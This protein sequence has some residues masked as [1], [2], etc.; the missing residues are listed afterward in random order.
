VVVD[1][2][3]DE[4]RSGTYYYIASVSEDDR[5]K[6]KATGDVVGFR[7]LGKNAK[8]EHVLQQVAN[9][10]TPL[11]K[12][13]CSEPC[14]II[15]SGNDL[16]GF[17][18]ESIIGAAFLDAM[19]GL[20][21]PYPAS[22]SASDYPRSASTVPKAF[23]GAWDELIS[24]RCE[25]REARFVIAG[26][27]FYNFEVEYD[28]TGVKLYSPTEMDL[29]TTYKDENG[30][31]EDGTWSFRLADGGKTLTSRK[32]SKTYFRRCPTSR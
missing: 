16:L 8:G 21:K 22:G 13:Y 9:D 20:L 4:E 14:R 29:F 30:A 17:N 19:N 12:S 10:G 15:H 3:Y 5:K 32:P 18:T 26:T 11:S 2:R 23:Q 28:V 24:D 27:K 6:G 1:H 31:Q 25:G 7:Y